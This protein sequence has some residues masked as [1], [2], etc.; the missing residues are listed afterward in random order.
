[1]ENEAAI[2]V[3]L[4]KDGGE[5]VMFPGIPGKTLEKAMETMAHL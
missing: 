5:R 4:A 2:A 1:M 3:Q